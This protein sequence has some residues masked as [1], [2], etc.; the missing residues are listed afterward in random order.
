MKNILKKIWLITCFTIKIILMIFG[1]LIALYCILLTST[2]IIKYPEKAIGYWNGELAFCIF[3]SG[4]LNMSF[5]Y[6]YI[7][8]NYHI[9]KIWKTLKS[10]LVI[11][12]LVVAI[13]YILT[14]YIPAYQDIYVKY[15]EL[16]M[17][18]K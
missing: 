16:L 11:I 1:A 9:S 3:I 12:G 5:L 2:A 8:K 4:C 15:S 17:V 13:M 6:H 14:F 7:V 18:N 10:W